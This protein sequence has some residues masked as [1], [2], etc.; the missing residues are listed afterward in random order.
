[1]LEKLFIAP[2]DTSVQAREDSLA[3]LGN[4]NRSHFR[5]KD[6]WDPNFQSGMYDIYD[7][8]DVSLSIYDQKAMGSFFHL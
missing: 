8:I 1:M 6:T 4:D 7:N 5:V 3:S 2:E